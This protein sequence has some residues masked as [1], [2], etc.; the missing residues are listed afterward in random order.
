VSIRPV[1]AVPFLVL[2]TSGV[3]TLKKLTGATYDI[4]EIPFAELREKIFTD[5]MTGTGTYDIIV[6]PSWFYGDYISNDWILFSD[7]Y[8]NDPR[9]PKWEPESIL[10]PLQEL[11]SWGGKWVGFNNDHDG[12]VLYYQRDIL[13]DPKWQE[14]FKKE[15]GKDLP[16][17]PKTWEEVYE[18]AKFFHGKDWNGDGDPDYGIT[19]HLKVAGQGFFHFM[20][21]SAPYVVSPAPGDDPQ[22]V[23]RYTGSIRRPWN[24]WS[25]L[26]VL[27]KLSTCSSNSPRP[28][29]RPCGAGAWERPGMLS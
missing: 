16:V 9:M 13:N 28:D 11:Y 27:W 6:G 25:T 7:K 15:T 14:E 18:V 3:R 23:T 24:L 4:V 29:P 19:M 10:P 1:L 17:P 26:L 5:L 2:S 22:K 12:Q 21:L 20:A 8:L